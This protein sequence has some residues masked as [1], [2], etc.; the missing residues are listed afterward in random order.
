MNT[1]KKKRPNMSHFGNPIYLSNTN[2]KDADCFSKYF[3]TIFKL[4]FQSHNDDIYL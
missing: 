2:T 3:F 1:G 4:R